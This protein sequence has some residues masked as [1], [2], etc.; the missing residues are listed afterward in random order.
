MVMMMM[1]M[2]MMLMLMLMVVVVVVVVVVTMP[3]Q[4]LD[5]YL[6]NGPNLDS[7]KM[8]GSQILI[9]LDHPAIAGY[10]S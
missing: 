3:I 7:T 5:L 1:V 10:V 6:T 8:I 4:G 9:S 2:M